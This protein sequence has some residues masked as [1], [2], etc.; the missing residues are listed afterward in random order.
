MAS[1]IRHNRARGTH[2]ID[3]MVNIVADLVQSG[4]SDDWIAKNIGMDADEL[5]R[6][7]QIS[8]LA[9]LFKDHEFSKAWAK[10]EQDASFYE[11]AQ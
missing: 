9:A 4:M 10:D 3:L 8:G 1:T 5:L 7:K 6:L 11:V 2:S